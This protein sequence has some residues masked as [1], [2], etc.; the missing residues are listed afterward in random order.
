MIRFNDGVMTEIKYKE[1]QAKQKEEKTRVG[2][3]KRLNLFFFDQENIVVSD[4]LWFYGCILLAVAFGI[5][6]CIFAFVVN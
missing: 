5:I 1:L 4:W 3:W 2:I 6:D